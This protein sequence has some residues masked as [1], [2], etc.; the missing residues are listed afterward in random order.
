[1]R[2][3]HVG[4]HAR[5]VQWALAGFLKGVLHAS[6]TSV[7]RDAPGIREVKLH[8]WIKSEIS[9]E[10]SSEAKLKGGTLSSKAGWYWQLCPT[11]WTS[12]ALSQEW[13]K[14][15][16]NNPVIWIMVPSLYSSPPPHIS[17]LSRTFQVILVVSGITSLQQHS[18]VPFCSQKYSK[19]WADRPCPFLAVGVQ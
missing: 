6:W 10:R 7:Y 17:D 16:Q 13:P 12:L 4:H 9:P 15:N 3:S 19:P 1:M 5:P 2:S 11:L 14:K 18:M 8:M